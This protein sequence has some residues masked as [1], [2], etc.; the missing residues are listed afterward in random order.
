MG[1]KVLWYTAALVGTYLVVANATN[2]GKVLTSGAS[3]YST[4]VKTLQGR[5]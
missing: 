2:A 5:G 1:K 4:A 3:A